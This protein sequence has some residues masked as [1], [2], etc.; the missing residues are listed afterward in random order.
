MNNKYLEKIAVS[1]E[2]ITKA[3]SRSKASPARLAEFS[4]N[5][6]KKAKDFLPKI[7]S[8]QVSGDIEAL[9]Q[10]IHSQNNRLAAGTEAAKKSLTLSIRGQ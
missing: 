2:L 8:S 3:I 9:H 7:K 6:L 10:R 4:N 5:S 1:A